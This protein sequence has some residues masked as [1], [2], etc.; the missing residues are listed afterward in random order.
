MEPVLETA[1]NFVVARQNEGR[2]VFDLPTGISER[3][4]AYQRQRVTT[5]LVRRR[6]LESAMLAREAQ[7]MAARMVPTLRWNTQS[8]SSA[9][10][11]I[12]PTSRALQKATLDQ[13][14]S[15]TSNCFVLTDDRVQVD[16][17]VACPM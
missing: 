2:R 4:G 8:D 11:Y 15:E 12:N 9:R 7:D 6:R 5:D 1:K 14:H 17:T 13:F 10:R 3:L 16:P